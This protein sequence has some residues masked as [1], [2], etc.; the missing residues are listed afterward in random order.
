MEPRPQQAHHE[1]PLNLQWQRLHHQLQPSMIHE[2]SLS[3]PMMAVP[4]TRPVPL[5]LSSHSRAPST[6]SILATVPYLDQIGSTQ[7]A[8]G[9]QVLVC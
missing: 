8:G 7:W 3:L 4:R 1:R 6:L 2:T 5:L 9:Y